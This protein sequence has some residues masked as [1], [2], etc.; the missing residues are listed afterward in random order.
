MNF[1][2]EFDDGTFAFPTQTP[3]NYDHGNDNPTG[4]WLN[5]CGAT[6]KTCSGFQYYGGFG[7][8]ANGNSFWRNF[9]AQ[10]IHP[11]THTVNFEGKI[12][13][14]DSW[15]GETFTVEMTDGQGNV[16]AT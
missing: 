8:C 2:Y 14:I 7:E 6:E 10:K 4:E 13:T 9:N 1:E 11:M 16:M 15:D 12:W 5:D 3:G